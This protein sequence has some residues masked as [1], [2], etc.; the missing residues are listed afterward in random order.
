MVGGTALKSK[1]ALLGWL[2]CASAALGGGLAV[3][4]TVA[5]DVV[6][7]TITAINGNMI[8]IQGQ[9]YPIASDSAAYAVVAHFKPGELVDVILDGPPKSSASH[10]INIVLHSGN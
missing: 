8:N 10:A 9:V 7:G 5:A 2:V 4:S 6:T 1:H 3:A